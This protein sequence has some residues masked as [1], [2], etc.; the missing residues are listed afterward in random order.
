MKIITCDHLSIYLYKCTVAV[1]SFSC[2]QTQLCTKD[3]PNNICILYFVLIRII[4]D[5]CIL[6]NIALVSF[7]SVGSALCDKIAHSNKNALQPV[8]Y[9]F[10]V[11]W[12]SHLPFS[13]KGSTFPTVNKHHPG[14]SEDT[15]SKWKTNSWTAEQSFTPSLLHRHHYRL[16]HVSMRSILISSLTTETEWAKKPRDQWPGFRIIALY[17]NAGFDLAAK[18]HSCGLQGLK[19]DG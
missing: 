1:Y 7:W 11:F 13:N 15:G 5:Y 12:G 17:Q 19:S 6:W 8:C 14:V 4:S 10:A 18:N 9:Y 2:Y 16:Q 3:L